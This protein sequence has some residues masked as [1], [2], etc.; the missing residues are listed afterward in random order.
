M[1]PLT[2]LILVLCG[3]TQTAEIGPEEFLKMMRGFHEELNSM[4]FVYE[5]SLE[6]LGP[7]GETEAANFNRKFQGAYIHRKDN[8]TVVDLYI[9]RDDPRF[10]YQRKI[11]S[12]LGNRAEL[13][14]S[15]PDNE[16]IEPTIQT[17]DGRDLSIFQDQYS[18]HMYY[19][20]PYLASLTDL[21]SYDYQFLGWEDL[22]GAHCAKIKL[23][24]VPRSAAPRAEIAKTNKPII[25]TIYWIDMKR[26][27]NALRIQGLR[28]GER[29]YE[30]NNTNLVR[31][32]DPSGAGV[33]LP[34]DGHFEQFEWERAFSKEPAF[35]GTYH[36]V[37]SSV[38]LN[39]KI[40]DSNT[41]VALYRDSVME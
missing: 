41:T 36:L 25:T 7:R 5:G 33:W 28:G 3:L 17:R 23:N 27:G 21:A 10:R 34:M 14:Q 35:R 39:Q 6:W 13:T 9:R 24:L 19:C 32:E 29:T 26:G 38:T 16:D 4:K 40:D 22:N 1:R 11:T 31:I 20:V 15:L 12:L 18:P 37:K 8:A 2:A 30:L